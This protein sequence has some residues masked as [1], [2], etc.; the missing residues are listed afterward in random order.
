V[1]LG[2]LQHQIERFEGR[3]VSVAALSV[4]AP[5]DSLAMIERLGITFPVLS[6]S[7]QA[8]IR[9]FRVQ[10][11]DT[12][13]LAIHAVYVLDANGTIFYRKVGLRRP[14]SRE[15]IDAIDAYRGEYPRT[16][17]KVAPRQRIAVA[18]PTNDFQALLTVSRVEERP[19]VIDSRRF[20]AVLTAYRTGS[21][22]DALVAFKRFIAEA[23]EAR[24]PELLDTAA[25]LIRQRFF[26]D[27]GEPIETGALL[28]W[29]LDRIREAETALESASDEDEADELLHTLAR[30]RAGLSV[31]R[32]TISNQA[33]AW[34]L[35]YVKTSLRSLREVVHAEIRARGASP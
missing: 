28:A 25:W 10:N 17:E 22:D 11:P 3:G 32:A 30:A 13:E 33:E 4:D 16:D 26:P 35:R 34:N 24:E 12:R 18:Y 1:Q 15:L 31:T 19:A 23:T 6:D 14:V 21:S 2:E 29:R 9:A 7:D 27:G 5:T 8:V 20:D